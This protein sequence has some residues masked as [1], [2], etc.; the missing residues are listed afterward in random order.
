M[1]KEECVKMRHAITIPER[2]HGYIEN[3]VFSKTPKSHVFTGVAVETADGSHYFRKQHNKG[4]YHMHNSEE[5]RLDGFTE[6]FNEV[7]TSDD[8]EIWI[9]DDNI[10]HIKE[11]ANVS[12]KEI[13]EA[14]SLIQEYAKQIK[15]A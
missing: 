9:D 14:A 1:R 11:I 15:Q 13:A 2:K 4:D 12:T 8:I 7:I 6:I 5:N 10:V 3:K